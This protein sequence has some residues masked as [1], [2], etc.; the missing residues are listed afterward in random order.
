MAYDAAVLADSPLFYL[1]CDET[2]VSGG[3]ADSSGNGRSASIIGSPSVHQTPVMPMGVGSFQLNSTGKYLQEAHAAW[4]NPSA[5]TFECWYRPASVSGNQAL[6]SRDGNTGSRGWTFYS[7]AG[8]LSADNGTNGTTGTATL[9]AGTAYHLAL[10]YDGTQARLYINGV[11][12]SGPFTRS[13]PAPTLNDMFVGVSHAGTA[14][15][16]NAL[17]GTIDH[18]AY[19]GAALSASQ[20]LAHFNAARIIPGERF[21]NAA[22]MRDGAV[23]GPIIAGDRFTAAAVMLDGLVGTVLPGEAFAIEAVMLDGALAL[24]VG[25]DSSNALNGRSRGGRGVVTLTAPVVAP[26]TPPAALVDKAIGF[27]M[28]V[29]VKGRPT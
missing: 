28:P 14:G 4:M 17:N 16:A 6:G 29:L 1:K 24:E 20:L 21:L 22:V 3:A 10:T 23:K 19:Y 12:D 27:P 25:T 18:V 11:L 26:V 13:M 2:S 9:V 8:K 7:I 5:W 15:F